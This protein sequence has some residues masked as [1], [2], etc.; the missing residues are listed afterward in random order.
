M[1][2]TAVCLFV[3]GTLGAAASHD[4]AKVEAVFGN[5]PLS[6]EANQGQAGPETRFLVRGA[7][8]SL[9]M[10]RT[11]AVLQLDQAGLRMSLKGAN[12]ASRAVGLEELPG[13][14]NYFLGND[15]RRWRTG[16]PTYARVRY[17]A[18]YPGVDLV[19]YGK[20]QQV[21]FDFVVAPG[22]DP[23]VIGLAID[24]ADGVEL[25][26]A[27]DVQ[28]KMDN[29]RFWLR[30]PL[31]Y[32]R[33][34]GGRRGIPAGY[35][36]AGKNEV[37]LRVGQYDAA[38]P[39]VIDPVLDYST[40]LGGRN[41]DSASAIAVDAAGNAYIAGSTRTDSL[42]FPLVDPLQ[43][44][45]K[46]WVAA[47]V[48]KLNPSGSGLIYATYLG[49][50]NGSNYPA[51]SAT[52]GTALAVDAA[53][54]VYV[55]GN[56]SDS[57]FPT[58][59]PIQKSLS[60]PADAFVAKLN[61]AGSALVYSTYLGG[62]SWDNAAA[63]AVDGAGRAYVTGTTAGGFP[64]ANAFQPKFGGEQDAFAVRLNPSGTALDYATY[65]GGS[66]YDVANAIAVDSLGNAYVAG[67]TR[68]PDFPVRNALR[69]VLNGGPVRT[70]D[71]GA[72]WRPVKVTTAVS[73]WAI[74][75]RTPSTIYAAGW[76]GISRST[77]AGETWAPAN[78]GLPNLRIAAL[79]IDPREPSTLYASSYAGGLYDPPSGM[80]K[81]TDGGGSWREIVLPEGYS[82]NYLG[83]SVLAIAI[84]PGN[85]AIVYAGH[86]TKGVIKS[87]DGGATWGT[88]GLTAG[89]A[90]LLIDPASPATL[91]AVLSDGTG[92]VAKTTDGG[93][94]WITLDRA[95]GSVQL[96]ALDPRHPR[97]LYAW[98]AIPG[99][100]P[101]GSIAKSTDGGLNWTGAGAWTNG[102]IAAMA[103]DGDTLYA[104]GSN[105]LF[106]S[107]DGG[108]TWQAAG[109]TAF[110][111]AVAIDPNDPGTVYA[112]T[113]YSMDAFLTKLDAA[114]RSLVFSTYLGGGD[115]DDARSVAV[116]AEGRAAVTGLTWSR[117]FPLSHAFQTSLGD[118]RP[119][120]SGPPG[121]VFVMKLS[122]SGS[123]LVYS[124]YLGGSGQ[125]SG[126]AIAV[127]G[128]G[129][130]YVAGTT[131][132]PDFPARNAVQPARGGHSFV[133]STN[134][135]LNWSGSAGAPAT[136]IQVVYV[137]SGSPPVLF[138][139]GDDGVLKSADGGANWT[140]T[141][142]RHTPI[143]VLAADPATATTIYAAG[144]AGVFR[145]TDGG[146]N[147]QPINNGITGARI[148]ALVIDS[149][150]PS[151]LYAGG[152]DG[153]FKTADGGQN[154][155]SV[156]RGLLPTRAL[157]IAQGVRSTLLAVGGPPYEGRLVASSDQGAGWV[158]VSDEVAY[159][160]ETDY[161]P[162][163]ILL[164]DPAN[165]DTIYLNLGDRIAKTTDGGRT[166]HF[167]D[168]PW[169]ICQ[170]RSL[171]IDPYTPSWVYG[172][173]TI[174]GSSCI[175]ISQDGGSSWISSSEGL[176]GVGVQA[177]AIDP[178][179]P[180]TLYASVDL[181]TDAWA[182][183]LNADGSLVY[184]TY[185]GGDRGETGAAIAVDAAGNA[186][187][188]GNTT[189]ADFPTARPLQGVFEG[190][191]SPYL[192]GDA[193]VVKLKE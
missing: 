84:D 1:V 155:V 49:G 74:D 73:L 97:T 10:E 113:S 92:R 24:G 13:K 137:Q 43:A 35:V 78:A 163:L 161:D 183:K 119:A 21:E 117:D 82:S 111:S 48:A 89:A 145:S 57:D 36:L 120:A 158:T 171:A 28:L 106:Q 165:S 7:G 162:D 33:T 81:S 26:P 134:H 132:S 71:G 91:Y 6:F 189:S 64:T 27:G 85:S 46:G 68:S 95:P 174:N 37:S 100:T 25:S 146:G 116:D 136:P 34:G 193:F 112:A 47:F 192:G 115:S 103:I 186:Y 30:K 135:A 102:W 62:P 87:I 15:P 123:E 168:V 188:A 114:G 179:S 185:L 59:N 133:K 61:A 8:C 17:E 191:T 94:D 54:N 138:G 180:G 101:A 52:Y 143:R 38:Q 40:Y 167:Q 58:R 175:A 45:P 109:V 69:P 9:R 126:L 56:T 178:A 154:W 147:W 32:Q 104:G 2:R 66:D 23:G 169:G 148:R 130:A 184:S 41:G 108:A 149:S 153:I 176:G 14:V 152:D 60:G 20:G 16:I 53:G 72:T 5:L 12:P 139:G 131:A 159:Y 170:I 11:G 90:R 99:A 140:N 122:A 70:S 22:A 164:V 166:F 98:A 182:A 156:N 107:R 141:S 173:G 118:S 160:S 86:S 65:L 79:A 127:D 44:D 150:N 51:Q 151:I 19:F 29:R 42:A 18:V 177:L 88:T 144:D 124:T 50:R 75:P 4:G 77:D 83:G 142:L 121:D 55:A 190:D 80:Y 129:N 63:I 39:L 67:N 157:A 93:D 125:D 3:W 187:V 31:V 76:L 172:G 181:G 128:L 105:G 96:L 110:V